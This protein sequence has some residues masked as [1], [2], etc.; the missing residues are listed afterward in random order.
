MAQGTKAAPATAPAAQAAAP[1]TPETQDEM[2]DKIIESAE[3]A[4]AEE[5]AAEEGEAE[6]SA[7]PEAPAAEAETEGEE[8]EPAAET[9]DAETQEVLKEFSGADGT[10]DKKGLAKAIKELKG[11][12]VLTEDE[13]VALRDYAAVYDLARTDP[14]VLKAIQEGE[15]RKRGRVAPARAG[16]NGHKSWEQVKAEARKIAEEKGQLEASIYL[17]EH[18]P[19]LQ[20]VEDLKTE[21]AREQG[22]KLNAEIKQDWAAHVEEYGAPDE[23][24]LSEM[25]EISQTLA[26]AG[27]HLK[28]TSIR[29]AALS[30]LGRLK[31]TKKGAAKPAAATLS[32]TRVVK[33]GGQA[34]S[35]VAAASQQK[36]A[37]SEVIDSI[38]AEVD[39]KKWK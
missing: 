31:M 15:A 23:Q 27:K 11:K 29:A 35:R 14:E 36:S 22:S 26:A 16:G 6:G 32:P 17:R 3:A 28:F 38:A 18:D 1:A 13:T 39:E 2:I 19:A 10:L 25:S 4:P 12:R 33:T 37:A 24:L 20:E 5:E 21:R 30:N 8:V 34:V 7:T 9:T